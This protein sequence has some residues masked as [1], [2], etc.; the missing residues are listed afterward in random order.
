MGN[1]SNPFL[2]KSL[3]TMDEVNQKFDALVFKLKEASV[4]F[5]AIAVDAVKAVAPWAVVSL[6]QSVLGNLAWMGGSMLA[7]KMWPDET[8]HSNGNWG[9]KRRSEDDIL[10]TAD[11]KPMSS[12]PTVTTAVPSMAVPSG[13]ALA[14]I[15]LYRG[16]IDP[17]RADILRSQLETLRGIR[18]EQIRTIAAIKGDWI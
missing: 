8:P 13:D 2:E 11:N 17:A 3:Q 12:V 1:V 4:M 6:R 10:R 5:S 18:A 7:R 16:G 9:A 14:R 15:G